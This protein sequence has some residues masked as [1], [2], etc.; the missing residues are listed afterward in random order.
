ME[1]QARS[2]PPKRNYRINEVCEYT[3]TQPYIL[4][5]WESEFPQLNPAKSRGGSPVYSR[6][7]IELVLRIRQLLYD[8]EYTIVGARRRLDQELKGR[9]PKTSRP[10]RRR[11]ARNH[12]PDPTDVTEVARAEDTGESGDHPP[13]LPTEEVV[14]ERV[15]SLLCVPALHIE[16]PDYSIWS[17]CRSSIRPPYLR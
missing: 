7:D 11:Q 15:E 16:N 1:P 12:D 8:E 4:R 6:K 3:D 13:R 9:A 10:A 2:I 14:D 17:T 5:F